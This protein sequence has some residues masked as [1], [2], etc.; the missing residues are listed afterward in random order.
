MVCS[1]AVLL[2]RHMPRGIVAGYRAVGDELDVCGV[3]R[4]LAFPRVTLGLQLTFHQAVVTAHCVGALGIPEPASDAPVV[5]PDVILVPLLGVDTAGT[6]L[7]QG[8][9]YYDR[10][11]AALRAVRPVVAVG[12]GWDIQ[13]IDMLPADPWD[14]PLDALATPSGWRDFTT[15]RDG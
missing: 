6:R 7:G 13:L 4:P 5:D 1:L 8:G 15:W 10:T 3:Y 14:A 11:L 9:G 2:D 12:I